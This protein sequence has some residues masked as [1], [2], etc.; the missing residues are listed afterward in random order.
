VPPTATETP[1]PG[2]VE[3]YLTLG[4]TQT[5]DG[6]SA[7]NEDILA[8]DGSGYSMYFDG[9]DVGLGSL[10]INSFSVLDD[11]EILISFTSASNGV[12]PI[13]FVD[14]S[15]IVKFTATS[16]GENTAG[17]FQLYFD[18]GDVGLSSSSEDIDAFSVLPS[19]HIVISTAGG[20][21]VSGTSGS[22]EDM[23]QFLPISLGNTTVGGWS[24]YFD[25]S[26]VGLSSSSEDID[27]A[28]VD[29]AGDI[30]LS[31]LGNFSVSGLSGNDED[32]VRFTP[33]SLGSSTSGTFV[34]PLFFDGSTRGVGSNDV[35]AFDL[36]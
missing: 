28:Y 9:S 18:G 4:S 12:L 34:S 22:D 8:F 3:L 10:A 19:G 21:S 14:D 16:L 7:T 31:T 5:I 1:V 27:G 25:G 33:A 2:S 30:F 35:V 32:I 26:D 20:V 23:V 29:E 6:V 17:S 36:P 15:D 24:L 11:D 13:G